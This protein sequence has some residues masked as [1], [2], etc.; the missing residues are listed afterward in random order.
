MVSNN[1]IYVRKVKRGPHPENE[2]VSVE[3][4][5]EGEMKHTLFLFPPVLLALATWT[6]DAGSAILLDQPTRNCR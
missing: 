3:N 2:K 4:R 6:F 1:Q 5:F